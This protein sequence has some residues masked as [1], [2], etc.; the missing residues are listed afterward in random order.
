VRYSAL[1]CLVDAIR[2]GTTTLID[3]HASPNAIHGSLD[4]IAEATQQAGVRTCLCYEV[5]RPRRPR[6]HSGLALPKTFALPNPRSRI[7]NPKSPLLSAFMPRSRCP[8]RRWPDC[9]AAARDLDLGF[10][11]HAAEDQADQQD[12]LRKSASGSSTA[13]VMRASSARRPSP[14]TACTSD[15]G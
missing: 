1:V 5:H 3:H 9:V 2:H 14:P 12:S 6:A 13:W 10:H 8:T 15:H 11:I 7:Q 4:V